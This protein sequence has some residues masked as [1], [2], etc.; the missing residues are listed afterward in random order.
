[1]EGLNNYLN[2]GKE[3]YNINIYNDGRPSPYGSETGLDLEEAIEELIY[4]D[5]IS[6]NYDE[7]E[8]EKALKGIKKNDYRMFGSGLSEIKVSKR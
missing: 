4:Y 7:D 2:E 5:V 1:M 3:T 8:L 6:D